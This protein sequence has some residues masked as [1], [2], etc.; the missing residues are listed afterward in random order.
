MNKLPTEKRNQL[1]LVAGLTLLVL[2]G[3]WTVLIAPLRQRVR[4]TAGRKAAIARNLDQVSRA[5]KNADRVAAELAE[6]RVA[7]AELEARMGSGDLYSWAIDTLRQF[8]LSHRVEIP[9]FSQIDGPRDMPLLAQFPYKQ[10]TLTI[11][12]SALFY[13]FGQFLAD[14]EN[15]SPYIRVLNLS[16]EPIPSLGVVEQE[17][18]A[19]KMDVVFL[20]KPRES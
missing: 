6:A 5:I 13:D 10:A 7:L 3:L 16:L 20:V 14:L 19:F 12:G 18:L 4:N 2:A 15:Q 17:K 1:I 9:Q 11:G 8:K